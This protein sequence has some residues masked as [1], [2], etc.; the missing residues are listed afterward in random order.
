VSQGQG[1]GLS[2]YFTGEEGGVAAVT[3]LNSEMPV[4][5]H[6]PNAFQ[7]RGG[8][9]QPN[10]APGSSLTVTV[11]QFPIYNSGSSGVNTIMSSQTSG[12]VGGSSPHDN[13]MPSLALNFCI[14]LQ[15]LFPPRG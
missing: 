14:A 13:M 1:Q 5:S 15:G 9:P 3:L 8:T 11:G 10:P 4:H 2:P 7:A 6:A 12:P